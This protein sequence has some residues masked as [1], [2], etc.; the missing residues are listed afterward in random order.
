MNLQNY[1]QNINN[2]QGANPFTPNQVFYY[3]PQSQVRMQQIPLVQAPRSLPHQKRTAT[4]PPN[5]E[6]SAKRARFNEVNDENLS[7]PLIG[8]TPKCTPPTIPVVRNITNQHLISFDNKQPVPKP[9]NFENFAVSKVQNCINL[10]MKYYEQKNFDLLEQEAEKGLTLEKVTYFEKIKLLELLSKAL[11]EK[12]DF[13]NCQKVLQTGLSLDELPNLY[14]IQFLLMLAQIYQKQ[15]DFSGAQKAAQA[16]LDIPECDNYQKMHLVIILA[17]SFLK[18]KDFDGAQKAAQ[19]AQATINLL[20][21]TYLQKSRFCVQLSIIFLELEDF[22]HVQKAAQA[23]LALPECTNFQKIFFLTNL[24]QSFL[25]QKDFDG[26]QK[27]AQDAQALID[28]SEIKNS[29]K[30]EFFMRLSKLYLKKDLSAAQKTAETAFNLPGCTN[31]QKSKLLITLSKIY[32]EQKDFIRSQQTAQD[33]QIK[34]N[35]PEITN[36]RKIELLISLANLYLEQ[37]D[38][39]RSQKAGEAALNIPECTNSQKTRLLVPLS[40]IYLEQ[41]D[42]IRAQKAAQ[43]GLKGLDQQHEDRNNLKI[44]FLII[45]FM[46]YKDQKNQTAELKIILDIVDLINTKENPFKIDILNALSNFISIEQV[47]IELVEILKSTQDLPSQQSIWKAIEVLAH[48]K[49]LQ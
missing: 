43:I 23:G 12:K 13:V 30:I 24:A 8:R 35:L 20:K 2:Q 11:W 45:L 41:K 21:C 16:A 46:V 33:A 48:V 47:M 29:L 9:L 6:N 40:K 3:W 7:Q 5:G 42:F 18:Q 49:Q 1:R 19:E 36:S 34:I 25:M 14:K 22:T 39:I 28:V 17:E 38:F 37:K 32:L 15:K 44:E 31:F 4:T 10:C 27:A 26:A